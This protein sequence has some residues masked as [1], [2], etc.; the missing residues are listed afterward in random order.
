MATITIGH[1]EANVTITGNKLEGNL[2]LIEHGDSSRPL[3]RISSAHDTK[4]GAYLKGTT[5]PFSRDISGEIILL[6]GVYDEK[7]SAKADKD[8]FEILLPDKDLKIGELSTVVKFQDKLFTVINTVTGGIDMRV[9]GVQ[10]TPTFEYVET[11][12]IN[13]LGSTTTV[14]RSYKASARLFGVT[15]RSPEATL[16]A[17]FSFDEKDVLSNI[18]RALGDAIEALVRKNMFVG[19]LIDLGEEVAG[20]VSRYGSRIVDAIGSVFDGGESSPSPPVLINPFSDSHQLDVNTLIQW[21]QSVSTSD[22]LQKFPL[23]K[24]YGR[25]V[26]SALTNCA[27]P[28]VYK[29]LSIGR[30]DN[31]S[32]HVDRDNSLHYQ[33]PFNWITFGDVRSDSPHYGCFDIQGVRICWGHGQ[34]K[35]DGRQDVR[36]RGGFGGGTASVV[37]TSSQGGIQAHL[38]VVNVDNAKG[39]FTIDRDSAIDGKV[40]FT[41]IAIGSSPGMRAGNS[42]LISNGLMLQWG[43]S[44]SSLDYEQLFEFHRPFASMQFSVVTNVAKANVRSGLALSRPIN[45]S[46]FVIDRNSR[47]DGKLPFYWIAVGR[48]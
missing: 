32:F 21:G 1:L 20:Y 34:S 35:V 28:D 13:L 42:I 31:D 10:I 7:F 48:Y 22:G 39:E 37:V 24:R 33:I 16:T 19:P 17:E 3:L 11:S 44:T 4:Q 2:P 46:G 29:S 14:S 12:N 30:L 26:G 45:E 36:M 8:G 40:N 23:A 15:V 9:L 27:R 6:A 38:S 47:I 18:H 41:Y 43:K 5:R 25:P